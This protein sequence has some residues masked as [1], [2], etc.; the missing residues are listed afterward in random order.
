[1]LGSTVNPFATGIAS[2]IADVPI[3]EG[4]IGRLVILIVGLAIGI[5]FVLRYADR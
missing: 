5:V 4:L 1:M 3:S 2:G